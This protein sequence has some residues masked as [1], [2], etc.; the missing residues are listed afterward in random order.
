MCGRAGARPLRDASRCGGQPHAR[1]FPSVE[2]ARGVAI[3][4]RRRRMRGGEQHAHAFEQGFVFGMLRVDPGVFRVFQ[5]LALDARDFGERGVGRGA[6][7]RAVGFHRVFRRSGPRS[8]RRRAP[9]AGC[10]RSRF[11]STRRSGRR[12][13]NV[14]PCARRATVGVRSSR[15][16]RCAASLPLRPCGIACVCSAAFVSATRCAEMKSIK[17]CTWPGIRPSLCATGK[18]AFSNA[19]S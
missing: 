14:S 9:D 13:R 5:R 19:S 15:P 4:A 18:A 10:C 3:C 11:R 8:W 6:R 1:P 7:R 12:R 17:P 16:I 2:R